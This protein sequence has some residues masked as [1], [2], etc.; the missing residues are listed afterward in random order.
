MPHVVTVSTP[1]GMN[2]APRSPTMTLLGL[3]SMEYVGA[4]ETA[5]VPG[6]VVLPVPT[7]V[8][9]AGLMKTLAVLLRPVKRRCTAARGHV[10]VVGDGD[11]V[12]GGVGDDD[13]EMSV[14]TCTACTQSYR[15]VSHV[16]SM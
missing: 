11:G 6:H 10:G 13:G 12:C 9:L 2:A 3:A 8:G 7:S 5:P 4:T 14:I 15:G 1:P 16:T